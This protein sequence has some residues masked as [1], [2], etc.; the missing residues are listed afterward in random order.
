MRVAGLVST[1]KAASTTFGVLIREKRAVN[2]EMSLSGTK[3]HSF[4]PNRRMI[5]F[6]GLHGLLRRQ[7]RPALRSAC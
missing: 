4:R 2:F 3:Y 5:A 6:C 1:L 7:K